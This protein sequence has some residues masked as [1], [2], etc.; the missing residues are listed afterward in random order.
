MTKKKSESFEQQVSQ[1][2]ATGHSRTHAANLLGIER[3]KF[4]ELCKLLPDVVW[5]AVNKS[6]R[7]RSGQAKRLETLQRR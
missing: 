7:D 1:L 6:I 4:Y 3:R 2:A 5:P